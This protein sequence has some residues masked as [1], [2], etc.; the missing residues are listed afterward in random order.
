[1][2]LTRKHLKHLQL[3]ALVAV[4]VLAAS[5]CVSYDQAGNPTGWAYEYFGKPA[6][7]FLDFLAGIFGGSYGMAIII[8]TI[9]TRIFMLPSSLKMTK[10]SMIS[11]ARMKIAQPELDEIRAE[12]EATND[13]AERARLQNEQ[14]AVYKK[15]DINMLGGMSGCL[16]LLIQMPIISAVY[17]AIRTSPA[18]QESSF[19]GIH[20]GER[21]LI[22]V[23]GVVAVTLLQS[24]LMQRAMPASDNPAAAQT[25]KAMFW[26][27]PIMLGW[28]SWVS[29]AG[30]GLYFL[31]GGIFYVFQQLYTNKVVR[32]KIAQILEEEAKQY[33]ERPKHER[34]PAASATQTTTSGKQR[35]VPTKE[36]IET[37][38]KRRNAGKQQRN[39]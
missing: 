20:L 12:M 27:N 21:S 17:A 6:T 10:N 28:I 16:P 5:G 39:R 30:L 8:V 15:Y 38:N 18:I 31:A 33:K 37:G 32:P 36:V 7:A 2:K 25:G 13:P 23:I 14:M 24:W 1:M 29:A 11:Q 19:L 34:K 22:L 9:I 3:L 26:M 4:V 35:L